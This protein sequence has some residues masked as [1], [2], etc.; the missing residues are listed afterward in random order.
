VHRSSSYKEITNNKGG[1]IGKRKKPP[2]LYEEGKK[3]RGKNGETDHE[4]ERKETSLKRLTNLS[5]LVRTK[6][7]G[8]FL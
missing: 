7:G 1:L 5:A 6:S 3:T 2:S 4:S 8:N